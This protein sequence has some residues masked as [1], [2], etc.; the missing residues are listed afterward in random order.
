V[1]KGYGGLIAVD[2]VNLR[3]HRGEKVVI[4]GPSGSGKS[5]LLRAVNILEEIDQGE[6]IFEGRPVGYVMRKGRR[7]LDRQHRIC[8]LRSEIGMVFQHFHLF[9]HLTVLGNVMEGPVTVLK[10]KQEQARSIAMDMLT[11]VGLI[12]K[13]DVFPATL[14]GGQKQRVAIARALAMQPKLMLFDEPTSALDPELV[15]EVFD[16]IR[17]LA[18]EGMTMIIVTHQMGF[19]REVADRVI[20]MEQG[21]FILDAPPDEF[22][23]AQLEHE[24]IRSFLERIL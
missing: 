10:M 5:T 21:S 1:T 8:A 18:R 20:F 6:I 2:G 24:R 15:G 7:H 9:P 17:S 13:K 12:D 3:V 19:A 4:V 16:V 22:F 23:C 11:K 14:S